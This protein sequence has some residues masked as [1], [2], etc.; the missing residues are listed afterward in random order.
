MSTLIALD[1]AYGSHEGPDIAV[2]AG[3]VF[4]DWGAAVPV[5]E[6]VAIVR[7]LAP[8]VPGRFFERELPCLLAVMQ[9]VEPPP[10]VVLIDG[11]VWLDGAQRRGLG[12]R[13]Y[14]ALDRPM[15][16]PAVV[17]VAKAPFVGAAALEVCRGESRRPLFVTAVGIDPAT[18]AAQV[19]GMHGAYRLPTL[20]KRADELGRKTLAAHR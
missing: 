5:A 8:Y 19:R 1:V 17:G 13:L 4:A 3:V 14:D 6:H 20:I 10:A 15:G 9:F 7:E 18:A 16:R 2:A 12:A 11:Y